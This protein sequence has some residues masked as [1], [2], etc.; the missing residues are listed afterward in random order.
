[1]TTNSQLTNASC[2]GDGCTYVRSAHGH[3][4]PNRVQDFSIGDI[5][6]CKECGNEIDLKDVELDVKAGDALTGT[7]EAVF[8]WFTCGAC[9]QMHGGSIDGDEFS[10]S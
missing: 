10:K 4:G 9:G 5:M 6:K 3:C 7:G 8:V 2:P 1:M